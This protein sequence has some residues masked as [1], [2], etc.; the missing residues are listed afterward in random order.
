VRRVLILG[1]YG[2]FGSYIAR[3]LASD[4]GIQLL[5]AGRSKEQACAF[6]ASLDAANSV[7]AHSIDIESGFQLNLGELA[8]DMVIHT[9]GPFQGQG[10]AVADACIDC[11]CHYVD[12]ADGREF[13]AGI[14]ELDSKAK[15][16]NVSVVSGA[17]SVPCLTAAIMD[18]ALPRFSAIQ[19][20]D[21]GISAAQQTNRGLA[22]ASSVLSYIGRPF[23]SLRN[24]RMK[25]VFGWQDLHSEHYPELGLRLFGNCDIPDLELFPHR[26]PTLR[27]IRFGAGHE[28]KLLHLATWLLSWGVRGR[29]LPP[30]NR[31]AERLLNWSFLFDPLGTSRSGFHMYLRGTDAGGR[32]RVERTYIVARQG[33]GPFIPCMPAIILAKRFAAGEL[34]QRGARPC[35]DLIDLDDFL[36]ALQGLDV[37]VLRDGSVFIKP[38]G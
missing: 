34:P 38:T 10:Y 4:Q 32:A 13:V 7:E 16:A 20:V 30:L 8:P 12:L 29:L 3:S 21:Y 11:G 36:S 31:H 17:S 26:Y 1:G 15:R 14:G 2:N 22:T 6:A 24:G 18:E 25:K 19:D 23:T 9:V 28:I 33:H 35:L 37:T 27:N 5:I